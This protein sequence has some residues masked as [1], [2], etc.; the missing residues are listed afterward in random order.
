MQFLASAEAHVQLPLESFYYG[1]IA[2]VIF[3]V[4]GLITW[5]YRVVANRHEHKNSNS[6]GHH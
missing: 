5:S 2:M 3:V 4:L 1:V 6:K